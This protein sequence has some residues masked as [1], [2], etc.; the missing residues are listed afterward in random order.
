MKMHS[1]VEFYIMFIA[2]FFLPLWE[3]YFVTIVVI[4]LLYAVV[5]LFLV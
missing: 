3:I 5:L 4:T 2:R 1:H